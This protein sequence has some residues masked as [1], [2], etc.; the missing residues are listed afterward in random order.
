MSSSS[1]SASCRSRKSRWNAG[2]RPRSRRR[3]GR[4]SCAAH[5]RSGSPPRTAMR[6]QR[7]EVR[8]SLPPSGCCASR[9]RRRSISAGRSTRCA[10]IPQ[11]STR[12]RSTATRSSVAGRCPR[13]P[14]A[15]L[16]PGTRALT[17]CNAGGLATGGYGSAVGALLAAWERGRAGARLGRRDAAAAA[18]RA[19]DSV[20]ARDRGD[21]VRGDRRLG[22]GVP[23][24]GRRGRRRS[25]PA[26]TG[27]RRTAI[28]PTRSAHMVSPC[29]R[30]LPRRPVLHR[31]AELDG[32][33]RHRTRRRDPDRGARRRRR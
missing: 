20:G 18:G 10:R 21:P 14:P 22:R 30:Q 27:S 9:V 1:T 8:I 26:P 23:D 25:S 31:R 6:S 11:A 13:T 12:E 19:S 32:R 4:W 16:A 3:S 24:G 15:L 5:R 29:L 2:R 7:P 28:P 17:H 33:P